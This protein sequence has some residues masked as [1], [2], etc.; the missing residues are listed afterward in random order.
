MMNDLRNRHKLV[1]MNRDQIVDL[2]GNPTNKTLSAFYYD[3]GFSKRGIN[4]GS[5]T[6]NFNEKGIVKGFRVWQG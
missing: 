4:T 1:G 2:L 5:F 6:I 3:L